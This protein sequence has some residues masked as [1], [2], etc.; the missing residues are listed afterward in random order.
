MQCPQCGR[1]LSDTAKFCSGCGLNLNTTEQ[2]RCPVCGAKQINGNLFCEQCGAALRPADET[3][4]SEPVRSE[5]ARIETPLQ[6]SRIRMFINKPEYNGP[7][8]TAG[9]VTGQR[10]SQRLYRI[11]LNDPSVLEADYPVELDGTMRQCAYVELGNPGIPHAV[12]PVAG[13]QD[14]LPIF[15]GVCGYVH[16]RFGCHCDIHRP[17]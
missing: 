7:E 3:K 8:T 14:F 16:Q 6:L 17:R 12:V 15:P 13:L 10:I 11:R 4:P 9:I 5:R 1:Q 2:L